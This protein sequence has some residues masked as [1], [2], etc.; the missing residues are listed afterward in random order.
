MYCFFVVFF[1]LLTVE[2]LNK[3]NISQTKFWKSI[4]KVGLVVGPFEVVNVDCF[5]TTSTVDVLSKWKSEF[6]DLFIPP[7]TLLVGVYTIFTLS[8]RP[9]VRD[10][11][12]FLIS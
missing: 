4:G 10:A 9:S 7:Q 11:V 3:C 6:S 1:F 12:F 8:G 5:T 2:L